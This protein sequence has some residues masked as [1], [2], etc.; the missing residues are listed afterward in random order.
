M[1]RSF[2]A[3]LVAMI[4]IGAVAASIGR[5]QVPVVAITGGKI[6]SM[7]GPVMESGAIVIRQ[8]TIEQIGSNVSAPAGATVID[9]R[10]KFVLPGLIDCHTHVG[11]TGDFI[12]ADTDE[13]VQVV[14][15]EMRVVDAIYTHSSELLRA[16]EAGITTVGVFPGGKNLV[17]GQGAVIKT[18]WGKP[19]TTVLLRGFAGLKLSL[20][21]E[22]KREADAPRTRMGEMAILRKTFREAAEFA[23]KEKDKG[24]LEEMR[25]R[26]MIELMQ[27]NVAGWTQAFRAGDL[28][29]A[30]TLSREFHFPLVLVYANESARILEEIRKAGVPVVFSPV[31]SMWYRWEKETYDPST[32]ARL[33][34]AKVPVAISAGEGSPYGVAALPIYAA[35]AVRW[36]LS[37][38]DALRAITVNPARILGVDSRVGSLEPG[39]D[40]DIVIFSGHPLD[41][42]SRVEK[43]MINGEI[44]FERK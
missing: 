43:V 12:G 19:L 9:A 24:V 20:G 3:P 33:A 13:S 14:T 6:F 17:G 44:V 21:E 16:C 5:P 34:A 2:Q 8:S 36:G 18:L 31:K 7:A 10:G 41:V 39:K 23:R 42:R 26:P 27:G 40:A 22:P 30:L 29:N 28:R 11:I 25:N 4:C 15:P 1:I 37:E 32:V 35:Y 38:E